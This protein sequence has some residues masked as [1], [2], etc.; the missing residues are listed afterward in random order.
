M[1]FTRKGRARRRGTAQR[2]RAAVLAMALVVSQA[3]GA[4]AWLPR[5]ARAATG[6]SLTIKSVTAYSGWVGMSDSGVTSHRFVD[7]DGVVVYCADPDLGTPAPGQT[8]SG[9]ETAGLT[10][11]YLLWHGYGGQGYAGS[12]Q[13]HDGEEAE[14]VTQLAV[15]LALFGDGSYRSRRL[16]PAAQAFYREAQAN[17]QADAPYAGTSRIY[18]T[19]GS[20]QRMVGQTVRTADLELRKA[21]SNPDMTD[22]NGCYSLAGARFGVFSD[23]ACTNLVTE[24]SA[25]EHGV[26]RAT[27]LLLGTYWVRETAAPAGFA[28]S[29]EVVE[30]EVGAAGAL[31]SLVDV[32]QNDPLFLSIEKV[33][34]ETGQAAAQGGGTL[35]GAEF[36]VDY[37]AG[38]YDEEGQL[39]EAPTRTWVL[40]TDESGRTSLADAQR[41]PATYLAGGDALYTASDGTATLPLGTVRVRETR[42]PEGYRAPD[43]SVCLHKITSSGTG[44]TVST[45]AIAAVAEAPIRGGASVQKLDRETSSTAP[46]G[47]A[48]LAG[49]LIEVVNASSHAVRVGER[50][51]EPGE[52]VLTLVTDEDGSAATEPRALPYGT[53]ALREVAAPEGY[54][55][56]ENWNPSFEV[57]EEGV[58]VDLTEK[59]GAVC[60]QVCRGDLRLVKAE[61]DSQRRMAHVAFA[62]TSLTTGESHVLVTDEN[63]ML[64]TSS[65]WRSHTE[66]TNASDAALATD[67]TVDDSLLDATAGVWFGGSA[68]AETAP[69]DA[70]GAL[71]YDTY[72]L[73]ELACA[74]NEGRH[75][76]STRVSVTRDGVNLDLGTMDDEATD[77]PALSTSLTHAGEKVVPEGEELTLTDAVACANLEPGRAYSLEGELHLVSAEGTDEGVVATGTANLVAE[78]PN[79]TCD[80]ELPVDTTG[81]A[82]KRLV[83]CETLRDEGGAIVAREADLADEGQ[84]VTVEAPPESVPR[85]P[86]LPKT[87]EPA[88]AAL[89]V[90]AAGAGATTLGSVAHLRSRRGRRTAEP[91]RRRTTAKGGRA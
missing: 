36:T 33:D 26:A 16:Y 40:R 76:V 88:S 91:R 70:L 51:F 11:D 15:W 39:P 82:G 42:A 35:A 25:D 79:G 89:L 86:E 81:M 45:G 90:L 66:R 52:A 59:D 1:S 56:D 48:S 78:D 18:G 85:V 22:G 14:A 13:G 55:V 7:A 24:V 28:L 80:L 72:D 47:S 74:A 29:D 38:L 57:R 46:L 67:G 50:D 10:V 17:A 21:S 73:T 6:S 71:P 83:A 65:A 30:V 32:P 61:E 20:V 44:E 84:S 9:A 68:T 12:V 64:D 63:G 5:Q 37:Y 19:R 75:L 31:A 60:D 43:K 77:T 58:M 49:A 54:L 3:L 27:G 62:L 69:D 53:Y 34:A 23:A 41:D 4:L 2:V 87:G 8:F